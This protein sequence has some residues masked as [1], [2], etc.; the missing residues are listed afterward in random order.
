MNTMKRMILAVAAVMLLM[1]LLTGLAEVTEE[2]TEERG[3]VTSIIW[4]DENGNP[5]AGPDGYAEI[6]YTYD[7]QQVTEVY[8]DAE[9]YPYATE[10]GYCGK[11]T[12]LDSRNM[13]SSIE[14]LD[15]YGKLTMTHMGYAMISYSHYTSGAERLVV[16]HG[17]DQRPCIVPS[18]G[19]AQVEDEYS[20]YTLVGRKFMNETGGL[21]DTQAGYAAM[22]K[23]MNKSRQ[24][25]RVW[26]EHADETPATGPDGWSY[27]V[28]DRDNNGRAVE[29][30]YYDIHDNLTDLG[31]CARETY[32]YDREGRATM[33]RYDAQ[34]NAIG[35]G[36][37]AVSVRRKT[38]NDKVLEETY[39]NADGEPTELPEGYATA[40]Y[41]YNAADQLELIQY[42]NAAGNKQACKYG[43]AAI[44]QIWD[45]TGQLLSKIYL[46]ENGQPVNNVSGVNKEQFVYDSEGRLKDTKK[47]DIDGNPVR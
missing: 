24:I 17:A 35:F 43:Y 12:T 14:Y 37:D 41:S 38:K 5:A 18:L 26:Y 23:K 10:G 25:I 32:T 15:A 22:K 20:G 44:S 34:D 19:Y 42:Y 7:Y 47:F 13:L 46:D 36:G 8:Y 33:T 45:V 27:C 9:G 30:R 3:R 11:R 16:F 2:R 6:R 21:V 31:G 1:P 29:V 40:A 39:L 4:K 28:T